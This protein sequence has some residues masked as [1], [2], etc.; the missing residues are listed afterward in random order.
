MSQGLGVP[1]QPAIGSISPQGLVIPPSPIGTIPAS[2]KH[3]R[4]LPTASAPPSVPHYSL[5]PKQLFPSP[6][7][8]AASVQSAGS[9]TDIA[10][11]SGLPQQGR[12]VTP[13]LGVNSNTTSTAVATDPEIKSDSSNLATTQ[14][15]SLFNSIPQ[16][17]MWR[18]ENES[19]KP[20][21]FAAVTG[22]NSYLFLVTI[23]LNKSAS[24]LSSFFLKYIHFKKYT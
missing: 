20:V 22:M 5:V 13:G 6:T 3:I 19:Q 7:S 2:P 11:Q 15:Y 21:N 17:P 9:S 18:P 8:T 23:Y 14:V 4:P 16:Q 12:S 1:S 24:I 10:H